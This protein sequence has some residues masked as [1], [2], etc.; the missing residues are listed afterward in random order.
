MDITRVLK[1]KIILVTFARLHYK[2][3]VSQKNAQ[4]FPGF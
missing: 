2:C 3:S 1:K 4:N